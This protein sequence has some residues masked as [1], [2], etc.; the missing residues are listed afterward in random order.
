MIAKK[1]KYTSFVDFMKYF[2]AETRPNLYLDAQAEMLV[3]Q[4][5]SDEDVGTYYHRFEELVN[6]V[7]RQPDDCVHQW[8]DGLRNGETRRWVLSSDCGGERLT[9]EKAWKHAAQIESNTHLSKVRRDGRTDVGKRGARRNVSAIS[10][11]KKDGKAAPTNQAKNQS[12]NQAK[13]P[14][15]NAASNP[16]ANQQQDSAK[17]GRG[18]GRGGRGGGRGGRGGRGGGRGGGQV[19]TA[20]VNAVQAGTG[21]HPRYSKESPAYYYDYLSSNLP[22]G[23]PRN[24]CFGCMKTGHGFDLK[25][26]K[27]GEA[28]PFCKTPFWSDDGHAAADCADLPSTAAAIQKTLQ[29]QD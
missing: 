4:Q 20:S 26:T 2:E 6:I 22:H 5:G 10:E 23:M 27:C 19:A 13:N 14:P 15:Q 21:R 16:P 9:M 17:G 8:I 3:C 7:G 1:E 25:F 24:F 29:L 28:C 11:E 18:G 12:Q